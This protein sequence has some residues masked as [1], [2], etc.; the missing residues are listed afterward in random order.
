MGEYLLKPA[1]KTL[2]ISILA[3]IILISFNGATALAITRDKVISN[4]KEYAALR[5]TVNTT[6]ERYDKYSIKGQPAIGEAYSFGN[7]DTPSQFLKKVAGG[8]MPR[9]WA[10]EDWMPTLPISDTCGIDC[11]GLVL[12]CWGL[13]F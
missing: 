2:L 12:R 4:A 11:S 13:N 5:W 3:F 10:N 9:N 6:N 8:K 7:M 1:K